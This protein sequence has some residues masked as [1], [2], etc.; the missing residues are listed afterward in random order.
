MAANLNGASK[1]MAAS[2]QLVPLHQ[3]SWFIFP[4]LSQFSALQ[5]QALLL[6]KCHSLFSRKKKCHLNPSLC[7]SAPRWVQMHQVAQDLP[8]PQLPAGT[9]ETPG[10]PFSGGR[11][12]FTLS[13]QTAST[14]TCKRRMDFLWGGPGAP[15]A[16]LLR[17]IRR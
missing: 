12:S 15:R 6:W 14:Q 13:H 10:G 16:H 17:K 4:Q 3:G 9:G 8:H 2:H 11:R 1:S 5:R 7:I